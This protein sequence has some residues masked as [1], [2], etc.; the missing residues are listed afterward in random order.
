MFSIK[1]LYM[2][3]YNYIYN[4]IVNNIFNSEMHRSDPLCL[5][6]R[7]K[8]LY[9]LIAGPNHMDKESLVKVNELRA[10]K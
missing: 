6:I 3:I 4:Y 1:L 7:R 2:V 10:S 9:L 8:K 5:L